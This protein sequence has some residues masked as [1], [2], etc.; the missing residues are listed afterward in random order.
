ME[1]GRKSTMDKTRAETKPS[2]RLEQGDEASAERVRAEPS[3]ERV[4][5]RRESD[6]ERK[7]ES[8]QRE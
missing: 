4:R 1:N 7:L 2:E 8:A 5:V 6:R 3:T